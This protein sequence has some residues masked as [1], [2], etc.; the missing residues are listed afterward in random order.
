MGVAGSIC[1]KM[2]FLLRPQPLL[3]FSLF[4]LP[5][6][7]RRGPIELK[8]AGKKKDENGRKGEGEERKKKVEWPATIKRPTAFA[9]ALCLPPFHLQITQA[10]SIHLAPKVKSSSGYR[11]TIHFPWPRVPYC[12]P[13]H[14]T[15]NQLTGGPFGP[16]FWRWKMASR[17]CFCWTASFPPFQFPKNRWLAFLPLEKWKESAGGWEKKM[18]GP[19]G[20]KV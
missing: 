6:L 10:W 20:Q 15:N 14:H 19:S 8:I 13:V 12:Q 17:F 4:R 11:R 7:S 18:L 16:I 2:A 5:H 9:W 3:L 1:T